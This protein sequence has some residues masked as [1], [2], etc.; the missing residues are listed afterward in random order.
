MSETL[1]LLMIP[2]AAT[3]ITKILTEEL[4]FEGARAKIIE[5]SAFWG[6]LVN[7]FACTLVWVS[8]VTIIFWAVGLWV[9]NLVFAVHFL[10]KLLGYLY[11]ATEKG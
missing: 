9:I 7:C 8:G 3:S 11:E 10:S 6:Y 5:C 2:L 4:I 1:Q